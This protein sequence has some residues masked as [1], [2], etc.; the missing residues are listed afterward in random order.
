M[1]FISH[2]SQSLFLCPVQAV[3]LPVSYQSTQC[4]ILN[5]VVYF[6]SAVDVHTVVCNFMFHFFFIIFMVTK[7]LRLE[8]VDY[9]FHNFCFC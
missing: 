7:C 3:E 1:H 5:Y 4:L 6:Y 8:G 9:S 2:T